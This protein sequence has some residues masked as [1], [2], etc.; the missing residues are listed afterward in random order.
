MNNLDTWGWYTASPWNGD[1]LPDGSYIALRAEQY[2]D[3]MGNSGNLNNW[4]TTMPW[5]FN[6]EN[7]EYDYSPQSP[8]QSASGVLRQAKPQDSE[9]D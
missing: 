8:S 4:V 9:Q 7:P 2:L 3:E 6:A 5:Q 1:P